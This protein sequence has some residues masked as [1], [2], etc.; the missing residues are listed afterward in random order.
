MWKK[1]EDGKETGLTLLKNCLRFQRELESPSR[2]RAWLQ[3]ES[4]SQGCAGRGRN[5]PSLKAWL[6]PS[7]SPLVLCFFL[8]LTSHTETHFMTY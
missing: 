8:T 3:I 4:R 2:L 6:D 7:L 1:N 5:L